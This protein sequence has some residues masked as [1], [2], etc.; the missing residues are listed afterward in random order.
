MSHE[1]DGAATG[2]PQAAA[3]QEGPGNDTSRGERSDLVFPD[4]FA[5]GAATSAYQIEGAV[6]ADGRGPSIWDTLC[7]VPGAIRDGD[8]GEVAADHYHRYRDDVALMAALGLGAYRFSVAW[9]RIQPTGSGPVNEAG[10]DFYRRLVDELLAAGI[11]PFPTLYHWDLPQALED[12][13]GWPERDTALRF[14]DYARLVFEALHDRVRHWATLNEPWCSALLGYASGEHA[15]GKQDPRLA[16]RAMHHLLLGHGLA[17]QGMRGIDRDARQGIVLNLAPV[18]AARTDGSGTLAE[19]MRR[20]DAIRNRAWTEPLLGGSYPDDV[21]RDLEAFGGLPVAEDDLPVIAE[22]LDWLGVNYYHDLFLEEAPGGRI[23]HLPGAAGVR[24]AAPGT[25]H[26]DMGWPITPDGLRALLVDL[27]TTYPDLPPL[28]VTEN[29]AAFDDPPEADGIHDTRRIRY[30]DAHLRAVHAAILGGVDVRGY[31]A[32]SLLDNF[33][34]SHGYAMRFGLVHV[35]YAT[36]GRTPRDS[37]L[38]YREVARR[39]GL[40]SVPAA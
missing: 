6:G 24:E 38:W 5:W 15:P 7:R 27:V 12:A 8:S 29:G 35:D 31:F 21:L 28:H 18:R 19:G 14:A 40:P 37:A 3:G 16:T 23:G 10:L 9:P 1:R 20:L 4:G 13:G 22:P 36:Q 2:K 17:V 32:W 33:E 11:E 34:W 26:T 30:L 39:N 25:E